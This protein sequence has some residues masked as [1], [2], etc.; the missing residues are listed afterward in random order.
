MNAGAIL[1]PSLVL[2]ALAGCHREFELPPLVTRSQYLEYYT[3]ADASVICLDDLLEREDRFIERTAGLLGLDAPPG[4]IDFVWDP[5]QDDSQP[6]ACDPNTDCYRHREEDDLSVVVSRALTHHHELVHAIEGQGLG[7]GAHQ[8]LEEGSAEYL[9]TL[10]STAF[11]PEEFPGAFKAMLAESPQPNDYRLAMHFVGSI[12]I[13]HGAAK[14]RALRARMPADAR[15]EEFAGVFAAE[16]GQSLDDALVEM[17]R[18]R[19]N[20]VDLFSGCGDGEAHELTWTDEGAL[21]ASIESSCGDPWFYGGGFSEGLAGFYG[22][23]IVEVPEAGYYEL[24]VGGVGDGPAPLRGLLTGCSFDTLDSQAASLN[25]QTDRWLLKP[26]R[27]SLA[28]AF[29][30]RSEA[31]GDARV[32][33]EYVAPPP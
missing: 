27:H 7:A 6:W 24:T 16:F 11:V 17:S 9:G 29:P 2:L 25:G 3:D 32:R 22:R 28:V 1:P 8:T 31:R 20:G 15:L 33:L 18:E 23:Y 13:R 4:T 14:Y 21:D 12:F 30:Q 5:V 10:G 26:G 19:V